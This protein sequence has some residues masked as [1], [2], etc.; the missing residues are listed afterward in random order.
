[1]ATDAANRGPQIYAVNV[2]F[3]VVAVCIVLLRIYTRAAIV[4][5]FGLD[6]WLIILATVFYVVFAVM[7]NNG[8]Y[9]GT[10]QHMANLDPD[11]IKNALMFWWYCYLFYVL[12]MVS[13]KLSFAWFLLR[14]TTT[15]TYSWIIYVA[16]LFT[17]LAGTVFFF[18][19]L[20]QCNPISYYWD[21]S[22]PGSCLKMDVVMAVAYIYSAFSVVTDFTFAILPGFLIW[23]LNL[24]TRSKIAVIVLMSMGCVA[25][26]AILV[27]FGFLPTLRDPDFLWA[28]V[29]LVIWTSVEMG[30]AISAASLATLRPLVKAVA[31]KLGIASQPSMISP[32]HPSIRISSG[33]KPSRTAAAD[34][35]NNNVYVLSEFSQGIASPAMGVNGKMGTHST[36]YT[37]IG[38]K[39]HLG[40]ETYPES[41]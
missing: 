3:S 24:K 2:F 39:K 6:D 8:V 32:G 34:P 13:S 36:A 33:N 20:L 10:G 12:A 22:Q 26:S 17:V 21:R 14:I 30:L 9:H 37:E 16:S 5:A 31:L 18:V 1:M 23:S 35:F 29:D 25:S 28:T 19:T 40:K 4:K 11:A 41:D 15:K 27:R 7:S 38:A